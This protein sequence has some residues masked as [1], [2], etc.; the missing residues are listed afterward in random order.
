VLD[1]QGDGLAVDVLL[2]EVEVLFE[3]IGRYE[4]DA[5][6]FE[7]LECGVDVGQRRC[8]VAERG[9][10]R[11]TASERVAAERLVARA[12]RDRL[13][14]RVERLTRPVHFRVGQ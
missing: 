13:V 4:T 14:G 9:V 8:R 12:E 11:G 5:Q 3:E 2:R 7:E 1:L 10:R 6:P